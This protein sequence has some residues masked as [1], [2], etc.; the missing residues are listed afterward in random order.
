ML[1]EKQVTQ[2]LEEVGDEP[3]KILALVGQLLDEVEQA[4]RVPVDDEVADPKERLLL[5]GSEEL[6]DCLNR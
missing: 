5:D 6:E 4:G 1:H 2:V 3:R